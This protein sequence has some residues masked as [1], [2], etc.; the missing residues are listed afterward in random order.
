MADYLDWSDLQWSET[1]LVIA[2]KTGSYAGAK[3][4]PLKNYK[5]YQIAKWVIDKFK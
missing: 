2:P 4:A 5:Y 1:S 3:I